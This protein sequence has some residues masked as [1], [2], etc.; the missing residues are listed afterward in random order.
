LGQFQIPP[1]C[2]GM[3]PDYSYGSSNA[4]ANPT[5]TP[6]ITSCGTTPVVAKVILKNLNFSLIRDYFL[7]KNKST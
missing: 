6:E 3:V 1:F 7:F 5:Y 4:S 2:G